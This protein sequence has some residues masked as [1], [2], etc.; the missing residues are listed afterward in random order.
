LR[1]FPIVRLVET[2]A[3]LLAG[4]SVPY[5]LKRS[6][7]R[8]TLSLRVHETGQ[9]LVNAPL[10]LPLDHIEDFMQMHAGWL[11][12][13]LARRRRPFVWRDGMELPY[14][15]GTLRLTLVGPGAVRRPE[16]LALA[17]D[18]PAR[19]G[20]RST[21]SHDH[22]PRLEGNRL[23]CLGPRTSLEAR[24]TDWYRRQAKLIL[25]RR[26]ATLSRGVGWVEPAWRLSDARTR[27]GSLSAKGVVSLNWRLIKASREEIDYVICHEL[28]HFRH[29]NHSAAFWREVGRLCPDC[30][31]VRARLRACN[32]LYF[33][34]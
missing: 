24:V 32:S 23:V 17:L 6:S 27:W 10:R 13:H 15:G 30:P 19:R 12:G 34:F 16:Q 18:E 2:S 26:L 5:M 4:R 8:R 7:A 33:Q 21:G 22:A 31:A 3:I 20:A 9:V 11:M 25:G 1:K 28:A 29:R 14:L